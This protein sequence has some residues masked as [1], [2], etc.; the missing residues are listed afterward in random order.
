[1]TTTNDASWRTW[2]TR[3]RITLGVGAFATLGLLAFLYAPI[4]FH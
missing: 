1:M 3:T 2:S 4:L